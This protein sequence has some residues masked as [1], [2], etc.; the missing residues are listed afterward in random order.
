MIRQL[1]PK[2][3]LRDGYGFDFFWADQALAV[4]RED[5]GND[6]FVSVCERCAISCRGAGRS[7]SWLNAAC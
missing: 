1:D 3:V 2:D 5:I 7:R 4:P 6:L